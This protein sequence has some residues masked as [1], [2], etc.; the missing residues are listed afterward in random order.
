MCVRI[1]SLCGGN[2][3]RT[4]PDLSADEKV[5]QA[6]YLAQRFADQV[7]KHTWRDKNIFFSVSENSSSKF[8][9]TNSSSKDSL[10]TFM[11]CRRRVKQVFM[12]IKQLSSRPCQDFL[13]TVLDV[14]TPDDVRALAESE[15]ELSRRGQFE[16]VFPSRS[17]SRYLRFF[18]CPRYLNI[19]LDRWEQK[20][21]SAR[22]TGI[23]TIR[24]FNFLL[25]A[26]FNVNVK[27]GCTEVQRS[28]REA[29]FTLFV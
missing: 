1:W 3:E 12:Q 29:Y 15:D 24:V 27:G 19:L 17:S 14:L 2:R 10:S 9:N 13:S 6:F 18:E 11:C 28:R 20:H 25:L 7:Q 22:S 4:K 21:W 5:K 23:F 8:F 26:V 16:R